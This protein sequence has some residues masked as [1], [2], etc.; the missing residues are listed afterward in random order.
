MDRHQSWVVSKKLD[1]SSWGSELSC[2]FRISILKQQPHPNLYPPSRTLPLPFLAKLTPG[3]CRVRT[4]A[5]LRGCVIP[6]SESSLCVEETVAASAIQ[7]LGRVSDLQEPD[8]GT[9]KL[10]FSVETPLASHIKG[11]KLESHSDQSPA[12]LGWPWDQS[13]K[14]DWKNPARALGKCIY[15]WRW[16]RWEVSCKLNCP[17]VPFFSH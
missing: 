13:I 17:E 7:A 16:C 5:F 8:K 15:K 14:V 10:R 6:H 1:P 3:L 4:L 11:S 9:E 12:G 2:V